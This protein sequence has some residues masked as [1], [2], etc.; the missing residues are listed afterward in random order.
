MDSP[1]TVWGLLKQSRLMVRLKL[2]M[3]VVCIILLKMNGLECV[4]KIIVNAC[5]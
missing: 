3:C 1:R 2:S 5:N 4:R